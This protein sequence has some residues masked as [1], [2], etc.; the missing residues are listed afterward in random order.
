ML[1]TSVLVGLVLAAVLLRERQNSSN[2]IILVGRSP[3][4]AMVAVTLEQQT[5]GRGLT[6][7]RA[8]HLAEAAALA[9]NHAC[10]E[11]VL[12]GPTAPQSIP[13]V[14]A[15]GQAPEIVP[16]AEKLEQLLNRV[17]LEL[18]E[19]EPEAAAPG[20]TG[21]R[22]GR[23]R[24]SGGE[25]VLVTRRFALLL[26]AGLTVEQCLD[27]LIELVAVAVIFAF[28]TGRIAGLDRWF[29]QARS[30]SRTVFTEAAA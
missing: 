23:R 19:V 2:A 22:R 12:V 6:I 16:G 24:L 25:L 29:A 18:A 21:W 9:R 1:A 28:R 20:K 8:M 15:R 3:M 14:D 11:V 10:D 7:L 26:E 5:H 4:A 17:P 27:A 13:L 30:K